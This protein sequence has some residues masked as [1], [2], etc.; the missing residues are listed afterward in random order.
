MIQDLGIKKITNFKESKSQINAK[1]QISQP[2]I[3]YTLYIYD[4]ILSS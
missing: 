4:Q 2:T 3:R 1:T